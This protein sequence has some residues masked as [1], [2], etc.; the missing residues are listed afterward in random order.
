MY[1][2]V[3]VYV[4][5]CVRAC[6]RV[7]MYSTYG[8]CISNICICTCIKFVFPFHIYNVCTYIHTDLQYMR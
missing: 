1:V 7:F 2:H 8:M 6:V 5:V 3:N 4:C